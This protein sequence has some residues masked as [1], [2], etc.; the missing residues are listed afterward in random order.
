MQCYLNESPV[1]CNDLDLK[2]FIVAVANT[3]ATFISNS[4][5]RL[6]SAIP[7]EQ[8]ITQS[9]KI[10]FLNLQ[11]NNIKKFAKQY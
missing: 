4:R 5:D 6:N 8:N 3:G 7:L 9:L 10:I 1:Q 2:L 11:V